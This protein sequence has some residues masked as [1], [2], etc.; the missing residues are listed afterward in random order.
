MM[1]YRWIRTGYSALRMDGV[2][3]YNTIGSIDW[4]YFQQWLADG[5]VPS[6]E[7]HALPAIDPSNADKIPKE[8]KAAVLA[9]AILSGK[10][11]AQ[12]KAAFKTAWSSLP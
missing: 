5:G 1:K 9:A 3:V 2:V 6:P 10:T 8:I 4:E 11:I 12:A 7:A